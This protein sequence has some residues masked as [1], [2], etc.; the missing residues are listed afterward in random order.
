MMDVENVVVDGNA[1]IRKNAHAFLIEGIGSY[2]IISAAKADMLGVVSQTCTIV[3]R[4]I[5]FA[6]LIDTDGHNVFLSLYIV[7]LMKNIIT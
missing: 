5:F 6:G 1:S 2:L 4:T 7:I 3:D